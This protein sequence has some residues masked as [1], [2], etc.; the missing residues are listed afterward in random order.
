MQLTQLF[1]S[2]SM[3]VSSLYKIQYWTL[4][5]LTLKQNYFYFYKNDQLGLH[6]FPHIAKRLKANVASSE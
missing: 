3:C 2:Q 5:L 1:A 4:Q 6:S